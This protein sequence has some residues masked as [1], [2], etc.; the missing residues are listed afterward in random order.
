M[1]QVRTKIAVA[2][3]LIHNLQMLLWGL[4]LTFIPTGVLEVSST[5]YIGRTWNEIRVSNIRFT[6]LVEYYMRFWGIQGTL[7]AVTFTF[8]AFTAFLKNE[9]W[10]WFSILICA[11]IGWG[12][13]IVL[14]CK[15]GLS[16]ILWI[17]VLPLLFAFASLLVS[18]RQ[19]FNRKM[20]NK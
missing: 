1:T 14:D 11:S 3:L 10:S 19:V 20:T 9:K 6:D 7:L 15:L 8:I 2:L 12:S 17:D 16:S 13:A 4:L 5:S 18:I